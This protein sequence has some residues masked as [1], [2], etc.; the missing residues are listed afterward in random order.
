MIANLR[1]EYWHALALFR[2]SAEPSGSHDNQKK[3]VSI[4]ELRDD[5]L[6][7]NVRTRPVHMC[8][9]N[10]RLTIMGPFCGPDYPCSPS[11]SKMRLGDSKHENCRYGQFKDS[12]FRSKIDK[13]NQ[14]IFKHSDFGFWELFGSFGAL[15]DTNPY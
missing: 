2:S 5:T 10:A 1:G 3:R 15:T 14:M 4:Q 13:C 9:S 8:D 11:P 7:V 12:L 6:D